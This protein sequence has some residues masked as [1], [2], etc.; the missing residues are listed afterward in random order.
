MNDENSTDSNGKS[1]QSQIPYRAVPGQRQAALERRRGYPYRFP[2]DA[3]I[4][5][6]KFTVEENSRR[7]LRFF[8][9][10]RR[11]AQA[12]GGWTLSLPEFEVSSAS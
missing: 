12:L 9:W 6:G 3:R 5:G 4:L 8:Y 1:G 2:R 10:E 11:L 7:L